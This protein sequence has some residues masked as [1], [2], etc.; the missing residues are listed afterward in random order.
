MKLHNLPKRRIIMGV[1]FMSLMTLGLYGQVSAQER[2][3]VVTDINGM[4]NPITQNHIEKTIASAERDGAELVIIQ[5]N[6]PGGMASSTYKI[7]ES[8]LNSK[9]PT[10]IY[11]SPRGAQAASA[12][13]F[14]TA[15]AHVAVM[16]PGT[17]IGAASPI[18]MAG[19]ELKGTVKTKVTNDAAARMRGIAL[20][21]SLI[22]I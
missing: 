9:V 3:A 18:G 13:T 20:E 1:L 6:T 21:L 19:E 14:I 2:F 12:G 8:L 11:V 15:A 10:V 4:I 22:H 17:N 7:V 5:L 16:A